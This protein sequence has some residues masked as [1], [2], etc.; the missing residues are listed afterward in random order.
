M[1][2]RTIFVLALAGLLLLGLFAWRL[3]VAF[4][5]AF[6]E[7]VDT[8]EGVSWLQK[9]EQADV[10]GNENALRSLRDQQ[11]A[12]TAAQTTNALAGGNYRAAFRDTVIA[13]D[14]LV[15]ALTEYHI[16][17]RSQ[18]LADRKSVV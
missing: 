9:Q 15:K 7:D 6:P 16:L 12:T 1:Q 10:A 14:S 11:G 3:S 4:Y 17:D 2:K 5:R 13:G 18:V 8:S